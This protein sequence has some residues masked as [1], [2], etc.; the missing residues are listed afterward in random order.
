MSARDRERWDQKYAKRAPPSIVQPD[1]WLVETFQ[2]IQTSPGTAESGRRALD[3]ACGLGHNAIWLA[4]HGWQVDAVD[5]S[6]NGLELA[7][8][9]ANANDVRVSWMEADLD[10]WTP[11]PSGYDLAIVFRFLD[12]ETVPRVVRNGVR[13][14]GWL[15]YETFS[16]A[17]CERLDN[18][19]NNP[20]FTLA[21]DE[22]TTL[23][24]DFD[25]VAHREDILSDR[26]VERFL[27]QR[28][29]GG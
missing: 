15:V 19:I 27:G 6:L 28:Q 20:S 13:P 8:Q 11:A 7:G 3:V 4:R 18:Q 23:F 22:L 12:R 26:T 17:Q 21:P 9:S 25:V 29:L 5:I 1:E 2:V 16:V 14:G 10:E 24:P